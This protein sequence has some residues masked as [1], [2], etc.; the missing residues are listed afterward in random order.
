M[1]QWK[2]PGT[3]DGEKGRKAARGGKRKDGRKQLYRLDPA[4]MY[5]DLQI[6][7]GVARRVC[8][9]LY[10]LAV[11]LAN[12]RG[13]KNGKKKSGGRCELRFRVQTAGRERQGP[14]GSGAF[15]WRSHTPGRI[16]LR[17]SNM[18]RN[19]TSMHTSLVGLRE[20]L[21]SGIQKYLLANA[22]SW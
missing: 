16:L 5:W 8:P 15:S 10:A 3:K 13:I 12:F 2:R 22:S 1:R 7:A 11:L 17:S 4:C 9:V 21:S 18:K 20:E 6:P 19:E 14:G